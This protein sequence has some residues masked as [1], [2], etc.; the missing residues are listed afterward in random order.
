MGVSPA[1][2]LHRTANFRVWCFEGHLTLTVK[3]AKSYETKL[4]GGGND[5]LALIILEILLATEVRAH[6]CREDFYGFM[7]I[8]FD[9]GKISDLTVFSM[10]DTRDVLC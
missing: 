1:Q 6:F 4:G 3:H 9:R 5:N 10:T 2:I 7:V 8:C